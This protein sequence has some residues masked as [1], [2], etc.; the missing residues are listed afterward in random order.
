MAGTSAARR[1]C[2]RWFVRR[3]VP[4]LI[5]DYD[6]GADIWTRSIW[7]L[8]VLY[9]ARGLYALDLD[10]SVAANLLALALVIGALL[11][12]WIVANLLRSRPAFSWPRVVGPTEL[13]VFVV[14]PEIPSLLLGQWADA[15]KAA[16]LGV[17][18]LA[19]VYLATS[20][21]VVPT[22]RWGVERSLALGASLGS[23]LSRALPLLL[24]VV[25][26]LFFTGEVWQSVG[27][28]E[29]GSY[30]LVL[31]LF[32]AIG[33]GFVITRL[34]G[35]VRAAGELDSWEEV[36]QLVAHTPA[37]DLP[38]PFEGAPPPPDLTR[39]QYVNVALVGLVARTV[40]VA[41]VTLA[42]GFFL[43]ILGT[44]VIDEEVTQTFTSAEPDVL[45][46]WT[47]LGQDMVLTSALLRVAG[48]LA[49]FAG[50]S[51]TVSLVTDP[52]YR[53]EFRTDMASEVRELFAVQAVYRAARDPAPR[54]SL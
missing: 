40:Q 27:T 30:V 14:G 21:G 19:V 43:G 51:F 13:A 16:I 54:F 34:P 35:D 11:A 44:L 12:T 38:M 6:A 29:G 25:T 10:E 33:V 15:A 41:A 3:G 26:F 37:A 22:V 1:E 17:V 42:V 32:M 7:F 48:F 31:L 9:V 2:E 45:A 28:A 20:Y 5:D 24:V 36:R 52:A 18:A 46:S 47:F 53:E 4:H 8:V 23:V 49:T 50:L 39:R